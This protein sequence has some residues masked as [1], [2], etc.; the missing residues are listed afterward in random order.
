MNF[1]APTGH[2]LCGL[3]KN[4]DP[5]A[6]RR[7]AVG[8]VQA[9]SRFAKS[10]GVNNSKKDHL[11]L[12]SANEDDNGSRSGSLSWHTAPELD[13]CVLWGG[14][15]GLAKG[16]PKTTSPSPTSPMS[17]YDSVQVN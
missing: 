5:R 3:H 14:L 10:S 13:Y 16:T 6:R 17:S 9:L 12:S 8:A 1:T 4:F 15:A 7:N 11:T 2:N